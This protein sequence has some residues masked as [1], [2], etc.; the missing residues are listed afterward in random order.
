MTL[1]TVAFR[2]ETSRARRWPLVWQA[3]RLTV[4]ALTGQTGVFSRAATRAVTDSA[5]VSRTVNNHQPAWT[6]VGGV[7]ALD[8]GTSDALYWTTPLSMVALCGLITF[9]EAG[10]LAGSDTIFALTNGSAGTPYL[11][12]QSTGTQYRIVHHNGTSSVSSTMSGTAPTAGQTVSLRWTL[13]STGVVQIHQAINGAAETSATASGTL[14][15][16]AAWASPSR[17]YLNTGV[18]TD[19][20]SKFVGLVIGL[21]NQTQADLLEALAG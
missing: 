14:T 18:G 13:L 8:M 15:L 10:S 19:G 2:R 3:R 7:T 5:G 21:G 20:T 9:V 1:P 6:S 16:G 17:C 12:V 4:D 11:V